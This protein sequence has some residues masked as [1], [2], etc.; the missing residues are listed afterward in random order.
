MGEYV[1]IDSQ[2]EYPLTGTS[3]KKASFFEPEIV[4]YS[5]SLWSALWT[6]WSRFPIYWAGNLQANLAPV[7]P[8]M[9][10]RWTSCGQG[11]LWLSGEAQIIFFS[12]F[13]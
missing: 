2:N 11:L 6:C 10:W 3:W 7:F 1:G 13:S 4:G 8:Y 9:G 5:L 12:W